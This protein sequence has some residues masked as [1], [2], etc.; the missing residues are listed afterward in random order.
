MVAA[1][2]NNYTFKTQFLSPTQIKL[3]VSLAIKLNKAYLAEDLSTFLLVITQSRGN[4][5]G[6]F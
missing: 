6:D 2:T 1:S 4:L 3:V 5:E